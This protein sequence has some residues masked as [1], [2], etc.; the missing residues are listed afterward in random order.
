MVRVLRRVRGGRDPVQVAGS[1]GFPCPNPWIARSVLGPHRT[2]GAEKA[3]VPRLVAAR[4]A[5]PQPRSRTLKVLRDDAHARQRASTSA[6]RWRA[7]GNRL[8]S[9][10]LQDWPGADGD[11]CGPRRMGGSRGA[12]TASSGRLRACPPSAEGQRPA[13]SGCLAGN[14]CSRP[15][16]G[17]TETTTAPPDQ[18]GTPTT[19]V[20]NVFACFTR[21]E[22]TSGLPALGGSA[23]AIRAGRA[24]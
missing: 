17:V 8:I 5:R 9:R 10:L 23:R 22:G 20:A 6:P 3:T 19:N 24:W 1:A 11:A 15:G 21:S 7:P 4:P 12:V 13:P 14:A 2:P 18:R 16:V